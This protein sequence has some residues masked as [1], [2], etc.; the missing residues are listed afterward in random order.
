MWDQDRAISDPA[1][2][3]IDALSGFGR[4]IAELDVVA[5]SGFCFWSEGTGREANGHVQRKDRL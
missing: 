3:G 2:V 4:S 5:L 1:V